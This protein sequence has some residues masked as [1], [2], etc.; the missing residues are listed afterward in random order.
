ML[1]LSS[2]RAVRGCQ[3]MITKRNKEEVTTTTVDSAVNNKLHPASAGIDRKCLE[4]L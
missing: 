2:L 4:C 1:Q 3:Q